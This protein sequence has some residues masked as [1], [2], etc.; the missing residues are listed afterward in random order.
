LGN[1]ANGGTHCGQSQGGR[2]FTN[3]GEG[4]QINTCYGTAHGGFGGGGTGNL[5]TPGG[6]GGYSG[7]GADGCWSSYSDYGG[8]GGSYNAGT[9]QVNTPGTGSSNGS[10]SITFLTLN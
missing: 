1:G 7:G 3:G 8:G 6:G 10:V 4:G 2:S 5:G 9:S